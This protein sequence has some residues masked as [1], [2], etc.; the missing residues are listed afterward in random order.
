MRP[1]GSDVGRARALAALLAAAALAV[2]PAA[3]TADEADP[4]GP[5]GWL[6]LLGDRPEP[7][8]G[9]RWIVVLKARSLAD[10]VRASGG[11]A[12]EAQMRSWTAT[13]ER[14]QERAI[15][16]L[17][18]RGAPIEPEQTFVRTLNGFSAP[19]DP[20]VVSVLERDPLVEGVYRVRAAYP[21][22]ADTPTILATAAFGPDSGRRPSLV[23]P[24]FDGAGVTVALLDTG[25]DL[26]HPYLQGRLAPG[27]DI[28]DPG[29]DA[30]AEQNPTQP[31]R[32]ERH[33]TELAGLVAG[34]RGPAGLHGVATGATILPVRVAG[35]Q[36]DADGGV[37]VYGR[38]DQVL[39]GLEAAVDPDG[40]GATHDAARVALIGVVEPY[41]SFADGPLA[42]AVDGS[43]ALDTLVVTPA[44]NDGPAGPGYGSL[45][46]PGGGLAAL[47][48]TATDARRAVPT[49]HVLLR[50]GLRTLLS[51]EQP[52][53]GAVGPDETVVAPVVALAGNGSTE[54]VE[55]NPLE[56][57]FDESGYSTVGGAAALLPNGPTS[58]EVIR[59]LAA[60]GVRAVIVDGAVPAGSLGVD[61]PIEI[62]IL[63]VS[64][65]V[66]AQV[67]GA[68][69]DGIPVELSVGAA[70][71]SENAGA[72]AVA[73]FSSAGLPFSGSAKPELAAAGVGLATSEP[74]RTEGGAARYG[75]ISGSSAAAALVAGS[76]ALLASA[77]PDLDAVGL[78][79][80]LVASARR[81]TTLPGVASGLV[82][83][84]A[85]TGV[86]LVADPPTIA[87][88]PLHDPKGSASGTFTLRNV[89]RRP[90]AVTLA[91]VG[92]SPGVTVTT[93]RRALSLAP[94]A[95]ATVRVA[96]AA[97]ALP[98][99][100]GALTGAIRVVARRGGAVRIPWAS[101][102][103]VQDRPVVRAARLSRRTFTPSD[104]EPAVLTLVAG[105]I[106]G[107]V[108][109]PQLLPLQTL[110]LELYRGSR[111][112]GLLARLRDVLPGTYAFGVTGRGP[113][114]AR[115]AP[116]TYTLR[117]LGRPVGGGEPTS[118]L[119]PFRVR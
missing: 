51:G 116:G 46:G 55:G 21:A 58:P 108:D 40:D 50:A 80:A 66:A 34:S 95:S 74:G 56:R 94:G 54:V 36:P 68:L 71:V 57:L 4:G 90:L 9:E 49:V 33:G 119:V 23:I 76:A 48:V 63:G 30:G 38:T 1:R 62:P 52:L 24:G 92:S 35:W 101:P 93:S 110:E 64:G 97:A 98:D 113:R 27:I 73:P 5:E 25:V 89:S 65:A 70:A 91:P 99:A 75:A 10:R 11:R 84:A 109:R 100:P 106:D 88:E 72:G 16:A 79:G 60:A 41:A 81:R 15:A 117:V 87:V 8:L 77:R 32:P 53:G 3:S 103:P 39:A 85:A 86:E 43:L 114:G 19:L 78:R 44:G 17:A 42:R 7:Q 26:A 28:L 82:D 105:R 102:V 31:G 67:R 69:R 12:T 45:A 107:T 29:G 118:L 83:P 37:S 59:E 2:V 104:A 115:L 111:R 22:A 47:S 6:G 14:A 96:V 112:V 61:E 20:R 13:A 18:F